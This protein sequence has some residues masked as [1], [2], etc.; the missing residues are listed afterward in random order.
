M[1]LIDRRTFVAGAV[2]APMIIASG[3][4]N[5]MAQ[6]AKG[7]TICSFGGSYQDSQRSAIF[8]PFEKQTGIKVTEASGPSLAKLRAMAMSGNVEWDV[9]QV[10]EID[11]LA[12][13]ELDL[14]EKIDPQGIDATVRSQLLNGS[15]DP[16]GVVA[17]YYSAVIAYSTKKFSKDNRPNTWADVWDVKKFPG[18][19]IL[20][21]AT[22]AVRPNE[23]ALL[24]DGVSADKLYPLDLERSYNSLS[25]IRPNVAKWATTGAMS[26]Q[27]LVD[28]EADIGLCPNGRIAALI[29]QGAAVDYTWNQAQLMCDYY[30]IPKGAKNKDS[31]LKLIEFAN[32]PEPSA[33]MMRLVPYGLP[34]R[35]ALKLLPEE[36]ARQLPTFEPNL[37]QHFRLNAK[38]WAAKTNGRTNNDRNLDMWNR[39]SR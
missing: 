36:I 25:K 35:E 34:N 27:A 6:A 2:A 39:W 3:S 9:M 32:R 28:G 14:L 8:Q 23:I 31:A 17:N 13:I 26:P 30:V 37:K 5:A 18:P 7:V 21:A 33:E 19:R 1:T 20:P 29:R 22:Y 24:A 4:R 11:L 12:L 15:L 16:Y 10:T 38:W